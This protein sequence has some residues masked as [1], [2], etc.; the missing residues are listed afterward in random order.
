MDEDLKMKKGICIRLILTLSSSE[1]IKR[2][3]FI[4]EIKKD[5]KL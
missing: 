4:L 3:P 1:A 2:Q 5:F